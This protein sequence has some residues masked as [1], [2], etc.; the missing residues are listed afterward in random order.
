MVLSSC[1]CPLCLFT[2]SVTHF[3]NITEVV[4]RQWQ[5]DILRPGAT[6]RPFRMSPTNPSSSATL[7]LT[8]APT[9]LIFVEHATHCQS[10][11]ASATL[12]FEFARAPLSHENRCP[13]L[14][15]GYH[16]VRYTLSEEVVPTMVVCHHSTCGV[17]LG[18]VSLSC[19]ET[20]KGGYPR[21]L[22]HN[23]D[24]KIPTTSTGRAG[25]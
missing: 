6:A 8:F 19:P 16:E 24:V 20:V 4:L 18:I 25:F 1:K 7:I 23:L 22:N 2:S 14:L 5:S 13:L 11:A 17:T 9:I 21:I 3:E 10:P 15:E 12:S